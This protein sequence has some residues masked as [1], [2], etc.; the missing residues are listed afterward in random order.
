MAILSKLRADCD[1]DRKTAMRRYLTLL[2]GSSETPKDLSELKHLM[3]VLNKTTAETERDQKVLTQIIKHRQAMQNA[4]EVFSRIAPAEDAL[5]THDKETEAILAGR[6]E[7]AAQ[8]QSNLGG[9]YTIYTAGRE[10][11]AAINQLKSEF[12][13]LLADEPAANEA[14]LKTA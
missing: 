10:A 9:I 13:D 7:S 2:L 4:R 11:A 8:L 14:E 5:R 6:K 12:P 3:V 1:A